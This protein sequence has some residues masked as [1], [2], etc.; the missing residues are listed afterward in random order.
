MMSNR[1]GWAIALT[2]KEREAAL[3]LS[4]WTFMIIYLANMPNKE[5]L[6]IT[7]LEFLT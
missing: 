2:I 6:S 3:D 1:V 7:G 5:P 4:F